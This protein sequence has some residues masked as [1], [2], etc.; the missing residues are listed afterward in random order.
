M[1]KVKS[2]WRRY[3]TSLYKNNIIKKKTK[4]KNENKKLGQ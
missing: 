3:M 2:V 1:I 4:E